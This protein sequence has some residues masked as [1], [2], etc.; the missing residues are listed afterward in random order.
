MRLPGECVPDFVAALRRLAEH[1]KFGE[2]LNDMLRD[3][4][5]VGI[6]NERIQR[7]LLSE[8]DVEFKKAFEVARAMELAAKMQSTYN[9]KGLQ[10]ERDN[11]SVCDT[12][13]PDQTVHVIQGQ[14][15][16]P[17]YRCG[18]SGH[19]SAK[20]RFK[21]T[22][23]HK[24]KKVGHRARACKGKGLQEHIDHIRNSPLRLRSW[25]T[26]EL[27]VMMRF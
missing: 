24:C 27:T 17:C 15:S 22:T 20:C 1:C 18:N 8:G 5:V 14:K 9:S 11:S 4:L 23:C 16:V 19:L 13:S 3:R 6:Q 26:R 21:S 12:K 10:G 2:S 7:R 25:C